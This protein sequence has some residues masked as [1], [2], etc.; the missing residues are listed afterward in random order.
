MT[1]LEK[2]DI[3]PF[4][5]WCIMIIEIIQ[6]YDYNIKIQETINEMTTNESGAYLFMLFS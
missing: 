3:T 4:D 6:Q 1:I 2:D 5:C